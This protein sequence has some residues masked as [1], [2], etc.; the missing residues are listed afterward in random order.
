MDSLINE[1]QECDLPHAG[2]GLFLALRGIMKLS[3]ASAV[4][5]KLTV[6][7]LRLFIDVVLKISGVGRLAT[8]PLTSLIP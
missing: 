5:L 3:A 4:N 2:H 8:L 7:I 1:E 6:A